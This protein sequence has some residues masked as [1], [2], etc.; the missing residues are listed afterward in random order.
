MQ[1]LEDRCKHGIMHLPFLLCA[2][3]ALLLRFSEDDVN[4][5]LNLLP[6]RSLWLWEL[7]S[8]LEVDPSVR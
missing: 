6:C 1:S 3:V 8:V 7:R 2:L 4:L 5:R